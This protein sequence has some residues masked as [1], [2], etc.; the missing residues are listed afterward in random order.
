MKKT[1][2]WIFGIVFFGSFYLLFDYVKKEHGFTFSLILWIVI[3]IAIA[4]LYFFII[5]PI[6][7]KIDES[8]K[9][10]N[11]VNELEKRI[12]KIDKS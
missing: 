1:F 4:L 11:K 6:A 9:Y 8:R 3:M 5:N 2:V 10:K 7:K 12:D